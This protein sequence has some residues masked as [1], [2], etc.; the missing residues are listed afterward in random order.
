MQLRVL[1]RIGMGG[2]SFIYEATMPEG[3][4]V[5]LKQS[6]TTRKIQYPTLLH[7]ACTLSLLAGHPSIPAVYAWGRSQYFEYLTLDLLSV[8]V[9]DL[10][11]HK[12]VN[13][14]EVLPLLNQMLDSLEHLHSR[15]LIHRDIKPDNFL[16]GLGEDSGRV[17]LVDYGLAQYYRDPITLSHRALNTDHGFV[18]TGQYA[19]TLG[20]ACLAV[21][22]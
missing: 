4:A 2:F 12:P 1:K 3:K 18:G 11:K 7:E 22:T 8:P 13:V 17:H 9:I 16:L 6:H 20:S 19:S 15:H 21:T 14:V 10:T 5:A